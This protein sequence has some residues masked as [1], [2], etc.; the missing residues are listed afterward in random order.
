MSRSGE[1][2]VDKDALT[3]TSDYQELIIV[4]D[5][6]NHHI[7]ICCNYLLFRSEVGALLEFEV[8]NSTREG[9]IAVYSAKVDKSTSSYYPCFLT[10]IGC[11]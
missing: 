10:Y 7:R 3:I 4:T 6:M 8:A 2:R 5:I 9:E 1:S 11:K